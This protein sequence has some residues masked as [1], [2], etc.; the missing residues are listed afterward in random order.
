MSGGGGGGGG[1]SSSSSSRS[2]DYSSGQILHHGCILAPETQE[3]MNIS[4]HLL[5][6]DCIKLRTGM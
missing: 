6:T 2:V 5:S 4:E 1:G 3:G